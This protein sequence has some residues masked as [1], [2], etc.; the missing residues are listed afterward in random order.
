MLSYFLTLLLSYVLLLPV[1]ELNIW[2]AFYHRLLQCCCVTVD[3]QDG[4]T[5]PSSI[6][7]PWDDVSFAEMEVYLAKN[8]I[9]ILMASTEPGEHHV[10]A[11]GLLSKDRCS[12]L[13]QLDIVC[14]LYFV[15]QNGAFVSVPST[16]FCN[17]DLATDCSE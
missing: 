4:N 11:D 13:T 15:Q 3:W 10:V 5:A 1:D 16:D 7:I 6:F 8:G 17:W 12:E 2:L 9:E 14:L